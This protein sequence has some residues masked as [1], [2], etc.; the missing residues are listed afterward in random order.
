[1]S[2]LN[3]EVWQ[4][5]DL[6]LHRPDRLWQGAYH[7]ALVHSAMVAHP[8]PQKVAII[9]GGES[10]TLREVLRHDAVE[11]ATMVEINGERVDL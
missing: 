8:Y 1:M 10:A 6:R 4:H 5:A 11:E 2:N 3:A 9:D 7:E